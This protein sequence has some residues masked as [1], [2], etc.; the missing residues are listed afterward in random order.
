MGRG[1]GGGDAVKECAGGERTAGSIPSAS[2]TRRAF[3]GGLSAVGVGAGLREFSGK[4]SAAGEPIHFQYFHETWPTI[5]GN[6]STVA[7]RGYDAVWIQAPQKSDLTW[8]DQ[9][10][11]NDPPLGYQPVDFTTFD[12]EFG[13]EADLQALIDEAHNQGLEVYVDCVMNHMATGY[14]YDFPRFSYS[15]F[16]HDVGSIDDWSDD[17]QVEHGEL[18]GLPDLA[19]YE[20]STSDYVRGELMNYM[21]KIA[22]FGA[23]GYRYDAAKHVEEKYWRDHANPKADELGMARIGEVYS[24]SVDYVQGYVDTGMDAFDYPL[25]WVLHDAFSGGD[26]SQLKGAGLVA[27]DPWHAHPFVQNHD[28]GAPDQYHLA[29]AFVLTVEGTP[30]IYNLYPNAILDDDAV[31]NMVWVKKNLAGGETYWRHAG[32]DLAVYERYNNLLVG[33]NN[34]TGTR[35]RRVYTSWTNTTL[36]D[37]SGTASDVTTDGNGWVDLSVPAEGWVFYAPY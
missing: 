14:D 11:R 10:G 36:H 6:L 26:L 18:L 24:G 13:T 27:Q 8:E 32:T 22:S 7:D 5:T 4:A 35:S 1:A 25:Y 37:Y 12:S 31:N 20:S 33:I 17:H 2:L 30:M 23:D 16:H 15:D 29:H 9:S 34:A 28:E 19:Q 21:E 3:V